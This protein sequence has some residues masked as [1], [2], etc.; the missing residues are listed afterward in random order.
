MEESWKDPVVARR[1]AIA[2]LTTFLTMSYI[3]V[4]NP[5]ILGQAGL[6]VSAVVT[7]TVLAAALGSILMGLVGRLPYA[8]APG[9]GL[10]AFFTYDLVLRHKV[11]PEQA[12]GLVTW[13]GILFVILSATPLRREVARAIPQH[14][15]GAVGAGIGLFLAFIG[16]KSAGLIVDHPATLVS[17]GTLDRR[18]VIF[19][20]GLLVAAG[21]Y[22]QRKPYAFLVAIVGAT[23]LAFVLGRPEHLKPHEWASMPAQLSSPPDLSLLLRADLSG[24]V[25]SALLAPLVT[26]FFTDLFDSLS[27]FLGVSEAAGLVD[28]Q[29]EPLGLDRALAVD[30]LA[31]LGSGLVGTSP[32]TTYIESTAGI[33]A[34][35]RTGL[36]A[37]VAGLA[38]LPLMFFSPLVGIVPA[39]ATAPVLVLVGALMTRGF[40]GE[41]PFEE[42]LPAFATLALIPLTF[43]ITTGIL[44]GLILHPI[45]FLM[46]RREREVRPMGWVLLVVSVTLLIAEKG[47]S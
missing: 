6:E 31:T 33:E 35:G 30:A 36:T 13:S 47:V 11:T 45:C 21:L 46:A 16:L 10:N 18:H 27:T 43:S 28:E 23:A 4:A 20:V 12:L 2:G 15:R 8:L 5:L 19:L 29:G 17:L 40:S 41:R 38:F 32:A 9:M 34:G 39:F 7:A 1:E 22:R 37:V 25:S 26:L 24:A 42:Q 3:V 14:L 44:W